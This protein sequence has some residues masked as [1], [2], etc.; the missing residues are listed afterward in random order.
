MAESCISDNDIYAANH[1]PVGSNTATTGRTTVQEHIRQNNLNVAREAFDRAG[2]QEELSTVS[3]TE[4]NAVPEQPAPR[5]NIIANS[6]ARQATNPR[7][8]VFTEWGLKGQERLAEIHDQART[9]VDGTS[10]SDATLWGNFQNTVAKW[11][12]NDRHDLVHWIDGVATMTDRAGRKLLASQ[13]PLAQAIIGCVPKV[14]GMNSIFTGRID[15]ITQSLAPAA[16]RTGKTIDELY[17]LAGHYLNY[18]HAEEGNA[19]LLQRWKARLPEAVREREEFDAKIA[20]GKQLTSKEKRAYNRA[21]LEEK[22]IPKWIE[23]LEANLDNPYPPAKLKRRN[24]TNAE[25]ARLMEEMERTSGMTREELRSTAKAISTEFNYITK[26]LAQHGLIEPELLAQFPEFEWYAPQITKEANRTAIG[27]DTSIYMASKYEA[28]DGTMGGVDS[29]AASLGFFARRAAT[30][31]GSI[32]MAAVLRNL[33]LKQEKLKLNDRAKAAGEIYDPNLPEY[34][35]IG[36]RMERLR[37]NSDHNLV[38]MTVR[39]PIKQADGSIK[40]ERMHLYFKNDY[41]FGNA[42][43]AQLNNAINGNFKLGNPLIEGMKTLTGW[44]GQSFTRFQPGF[45][46]VGGLRD[47]ME[48]GV[49]ILNRAY[50]TD[51]GVRIEGSNLISNFYANSTRGTHMLMEAVLGKAEEGSA[52]A[53]YFNEFQREGVYQRYLPDR[54]QQP[55]TVEELSRQFSSLDKS[56][57]QQGL[58][59]IADQL[60]RS[61][62]KDFRRGLETM[63]DG[64]RRV[65]QRLDQWNDVLQNS[66]AFTHYITLREAGLSPRRA[67]AGARDLMDLSKAG[68]ITNY[69]SVISPFMRPTMQGA[70]ALAH[71][72]GLNARTPGE[73]LREGKKGWITLAAAGMAYSVLYPLVRQSLGQDEA[74]DWRAD[75]MKVG[76]LTS[77]LPI[78]IGDAGEYFRMP[79]GFGPQRIAATLGVCIDRIFRGAMEPAEAAFHVMYAVGRDI[80]PSNAP[81]FDFKDDP[82]GYIMRLVTPAGLTP[83]LDLSTNK[84][85]FGNKI[86]NDYNPEKPLSEQGRKSTPAIWHRAAKY[87]YRH[88]GPD[89]APEEL[90]HFVKS[91]TFGPVRLITSSITNTAD[92]TSAHMGMEMPDAYAPIKGIL[93]T[94]GTSLFYGRTGSTERNSFYAAKRDLLDEVRRKGVDL[95]AKGLKDEEKAGTLLKRMTDAGVDED[96]ARQVLALREAQTELRGLGT[97]FNKQWDGWENGVDD[98]DALLDAFNA[99]EAEQKKVYVK[100]LKQLEQ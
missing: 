47:Y 42:T 91:T 35:D 27:N 41:Q 77:S 96:R 82:A 30:E 28:M 67:G 34:K 72:F 9:L 85:T 90:M 49:H 45:A 11:F 79:T 98:Q 51:A 76:Q 86:Y 70:K 74:G 37:P 20:Q 52:A 12:E 63:K 80:A 54:F 81:Q 40:T 1:G 31:I 95:D 33:Y 25:A 66:A 44:Y 14:R 18:L 32:D 5:D 57:R 60:Q 16:K 73:V 61:E 100:F 62:F 22:N 3:G 89:W 2:V 58:S 26:E 83:F 46:I 50:Y 17:M 65:M 39:V 38:G 92:K 84:N 71:T 99:F 55:K 68:T 6:M 64:G 75:K 29:A 21:K 19:H 4:T 24:Y 87:I 43:G 97:E 88:G 15:N 69:L 78:G 10:T 23:E 94:M 7:S 13:N 56:L 59:S 8:K 53:R 48:R 93:Q 36:L